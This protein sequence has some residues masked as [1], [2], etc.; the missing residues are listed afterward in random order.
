MRSKR[1]EIETGA[2]LLSDLERQMHA[3]HQPHEQDPGD[4]I[5][6]E[7]SELRVSP[8]KYARFLAVEHGIANSEDK[9]N[10]VICS[11]G[12][13]QQLWEWAASKGRLSDC[14]DH[15]LFLMLL[16][17]APTRVLRRLFCHG[18]EGS[19]KTFFYHDQRDPT[20][21]CKILA[22]LNCCFCLS[23]S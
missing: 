3:S 13:L 11:N 21:I 4:A 1:K 19:G 23:K 10:A 2:R 5:S 7:V 18:P 14:Y 20:H 9:Y 22:M 15:V 16:A 8:A 12:P 17:E 6:V